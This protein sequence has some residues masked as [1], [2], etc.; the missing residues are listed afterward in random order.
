MGA[1]RHDDRTAVFLG[2]FIDRGP[3]Q[4]ESVM[5][6]RRMV[7]AGPAVAVMG[8]HELNAI[9][10]FLPD[11]ES[12]GEFL[13][14]HFSSKLGGRNREQHQEF[15]GEVEHRPEL[16]KEIIDWF[17]TLPLWLELQEIRVVHACWHSRFMAY[18][19]P[20]L[21][22]GGCLS[23]E[24]MVPAS[25]EPLDESE[26]DTPEPTVFKAVETLTKGV[27]IPLPA[28]HSFLDKDGHR[29]T[30]VRVRW[31]DA[32][33]ATFRTAAM[34]TEEER[35]ELPG[36]PIPGHARIGYSGTKPVFVGHYWFRGPHERLAPNAACVDY[37]IGKGGR[38]CAYRYDGEPS[39]QD[40]KFISLSNGEA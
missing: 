23:E 18:L 28:G 19:S 40:D 34:L 32:G 9:A 33:A 38:L 15:L 35:E 17:L 12:P 1:W 8:N 3:R 37:S 22:P 21:L 29:R 26:K 5:V 7:D 6:A 24:L 2:D 25:R 11:P 4:V 31:W 30:R 36:T 27:E 13:R 16:H 20:K 14:S 39:L 10:W